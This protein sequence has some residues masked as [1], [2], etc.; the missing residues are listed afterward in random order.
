MQGV[1]YSIGILVADN[2]KMAPVVGISAF[3]VAGLFSGFVVPIDELPEPVRSGSHLSFMKQSFGAYII[4]IYGR[5][6]CE[7]EKDE[8]SFIM[9][10]FDFE[11]DQFWP[12]MIGL[13]GQFVVWRFIALFVLMAKVGTFG[14]FL[15]KACCGL[16]AGRGKKRKV[17]PSAATSLEKQSSQLSVVSY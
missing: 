8:V 11:D 6:R 16:G 5:G 9:Y 17:Q 7:E 15:S 14:A 2:E 13:V 1:A 3:I 12:Y 10:A 4:A